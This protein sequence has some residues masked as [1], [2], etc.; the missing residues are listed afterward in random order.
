MP[1]GVRALGKVHILLRGLERWSLLRPLQWVAKATAADSGRAWHR[2]N[3]WFGGLSGAGHC[4]C[5][6]LSKFLRKE[7]SQF[8]RV[9][10][11]Q[12]EVVSGVEPK[13]QPLLVPGK[14]SNHGGFVDA[15]KWQNRKKT[16]S[17]EEELDRYEGFWISP[18]GKMVAYEEVTEAHIPQLL[19]WT[20]LQVGGSCWYPDGKSL[21]NFFLVAFIG[22]N[23]ITL[24]IM[25]FIK[26]HCL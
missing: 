26:N 25:K 18:D 8:L 2:Q 7:S 3:A 23:I 17:R 11:R 10:E 1:K 4:M 9:S 15:T 16:G 13:E 20:K 6:R 5:F 21:P 24:W 22:V 14:I 19:R 12:A